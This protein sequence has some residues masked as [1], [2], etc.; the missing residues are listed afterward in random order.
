ML[1]FDYLAHE[2]HASF[3]RHSVQIYN[4]PLP[5]LL[6]IHHPCVLLKQVHIIQLQKCPITLWTNVN[7]IWKKCPIILKFFNTDLWF[8]I[9]WLLRQLSWRPATCPK[10]SRNMTSPYPFWY[11]K[12]FNS[13]AAPLL[14]GNLSN[15][16]HP[17]A[18]DPPCNTP[19]LPSIDTTFK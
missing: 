3:F 18:T 2:T 17:H 1:V 13:N 12:N 11:P 14:W 7:L 9:V 16:K 10:I 15:I 4:L 5:L 8:L 19:S 6:Q